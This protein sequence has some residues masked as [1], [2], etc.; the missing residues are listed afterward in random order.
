MLR[1]SSC[2]LGALCFLFCCS[3]I[4]GGKRVRT[5]GDLL[6][7]YEIVERLQ[8]FRYYLHIYIFTSPRLD[9]LRRDVVGTKQELLL[10]I[11]VMYNNTSVCICVCLMTR[12]IDNTSRSI[13]SERALSDGGFVQTGRKLCGIIPGA[14]S[15]PHVT[16][17]HHH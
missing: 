16:G 14:R 13:D 7:N 17:Y 9:P 8:I 10:K 11:Y 3:R 2:R 4:C 12:T 15:P 5:E 1:L 6:A